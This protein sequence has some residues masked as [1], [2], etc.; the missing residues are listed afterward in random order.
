MCGIAGI[1]GN[2]TEQRL[3]R[4]GDT[5]RH[6][7]PDDEGI[8]QS[9]T[10]GLG[11]A[12][13][14]LSIIDLHTGHQPIFNEDRSVVTVFNGE[15]YNYREL[16]EELLTRGHRLATAS[17]TEVIVHLY[18]ELGTAFVYRLRGMFAIALWDEKKQQ[19]LLVRDR[20]GKKPLY[21]AELGGEFLFASEIKGI[22]TASP[23]PLS[24]D[25]D[26][27]GDY[28][29]WMV[30]PGPRTIYRKVHA[31]MPG[32][33]VL[34]RER[35]RVHRERYWRLPM[36]P[37]RDIS[38]SEAVEEVDHLLKEAVRLRLR[39]DVPV[40]CFLSGGI[41]SGLITA[42]AARLHSGRLTTITVGF[43]DDA[44]DER[45]LA[46]LVAER[47]GTDH[48]EMVL[49]GDLAGDLPAIVAAYD[50]PFGD[51]SAV[52]S[53]YLAREGRKLVKTT[54][55]GDGG[56]ELFAGYR[57]YVAGWIAAQ[58]GFLDS[59]ALRPLWRLLAGVAP[60]PRGFRSG[61]AFAHRLVRGLGMDSTSRYL[62]WSVD[63]WDHTTDGM[64]A[65][66]F[67][68]GGNRPAHSIADTV[69]SGMGW[70]DEGSGCGP[71]DRM[72]A[73]DFN[74]ILPFDLL[75]K[76]DI[77]TMQHGLETRSP[78]LDHELIEVV[79]RYPESLKLSGFRTKPLLRALAARYLPAPIGQA[80]K[81]GFEA[82]LVRWLRRDL[83]SLC[84][85][86]LLSRNGLVNEFF[87]RGELERLIRG[88]S[89]LDPGRWS[90]RLWLLL[91]LGLWDRNVYRGLGARLD[92]SASV[93]V[94]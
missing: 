69:G 39:S 32:E 52:P 44:F 18:E 19:L 37:K 71:I 68:Q 86:V 57:R 65:C 56:D 6:R 33:F 21:Y 8:W 13:R 83:H 94:G 11:L 43:E 58:L 5:L 2:A 60:T 7:G 78:L 1:W 59:T 38:Q 45:P 93:N 27:I 84:E 92:Q 20:V 16:R 90:R 17:D 26:A 48:H 23:A 25:P 54:L 77:A 80:P 3:R 70:Y 35:H 36:S 4:M 73:A 10:A 12:H 62:A 61:Y 31:V 40:G 91:V 47:Y 15:I 9:P 74:L 63:A 53:Y 42:L 22:A 82:P 89:H 76:M 87:E 30:V 14:R 46:R 28:L 55:N 34:V 67:R 88:E 72:M 85:D 24:I 49:R 75:V 79:A 51:A 29:T 41:D 66:N 81:R 64:N 50:Q